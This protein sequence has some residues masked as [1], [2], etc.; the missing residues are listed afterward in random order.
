MSTRKP[1]AAGLAALCALLG[2]LAFASAPAFA[3]ESH[4]FSNAFAGE[5][6]HA[7]SDPQGVAIQQ[8]TGEVYVVDGRNDRVEVFSAAGT[9]IRAFGSRGNGNGQFKEPTLIAI[10][11]STG[12]PG[13]VYVLDT[14][15]N[16]VQVFDAKG[17][18]LRQI[19]GEYV[20]QL[21]GVNEAITGVAVDST[22]NLWLIQA[23]G[24]LEEFPPG[25]VEP[26]RYLGTFANQ[27]RGG[28]GHLALDSSGHL[29]ALENCGCIAKSESSIAEVAVFGSRGLA[30]TIDPAS[31]DLYVDDGSAVTHFLSPNSEGTLNDSFGQ[32]GPNVLRAGLGIAVNG[33]SGDVYVAEDAA[34][35]V[36]VFTPA[37]IAE[38]GIEPASGVVQT[39]ATLH[40]TVNPDGLSVSGCEF[41]WGSNPETLTSTADCSPTPPYT[42]NVAQPVQAQLDNLTA[43]TTYYY[44]LAAT[45]AEG[46]SYSITGSFTTL[47]AVQGLSTGPAEDITASGAKFTGTLSPDG[48]DAHYYFEYSAIGATPEGSCT[49]ALGCFESPAFPPGVDAGSGGTNC[50][51][52]GGAECAQVAAEGVV[53]NLAPNTVYHYRLVAVDT[54]GA[55]Y[56]AESQLKTLGPPTIDS[57]SAEVPSESKLG[58]TSVTLQAQITPDGRATTYHFEYGETSSYGTSVPATPGVIGAGESPESVPPG[59][60]SGLRVDTTYHY[61]VVATNEYGTVTGPDQTFTTLLASL[62]EASASSVT[63]TSATLDAQINPLGIDTSCRFE[64]LT[65]ESYDASGYQA[66]ATLSCAGDLGEGETRV[67]A[68]IH[69]QGLASD[70]LYHYRVIA[71]NALGTV[72]SPD[73][74]F[75]TQGA[76]TQ[77]SLP[78][79]RAWEMVTPP[80][81]Q[82]AGIFPLGVRPS[83]D[84]IQAAQAGNGITFGANGSFVANPAGNRSIEVNQVISTRS[85]PGVWGSQD[86]TTPH[87]EG[88]EFIA[89]GSSAEYKLFSNDLSLGFVEPAGSTALPPLPAGSEHTIYLRRADGG[90][91]AL[92]SPANV[93]QG[94]KYGAI[95]FGDGTP[96]MHHIIIGGPACISAEEQ[97]TSYEW[98][99]GKLDLYTVLPDGEIVNGG[100]AGV[101]HGLSNDG[102]RVVWQHGSTLYLRDMAKK[103]TV[104]IAEIEEKQ[105]NGFQ[106]GD[107][108]E[109]RVFFTSNGAL[110]VFEVTSGGGEPLAGHTM[111]LT[112]SGTVYGVIGASEDGSSVYFVD[113]A[114]LG[115][116]AEHGAEREGRNLYVEHYDQTKKAWVQPVFIAA[117]SREDRPTWG[118]SSGENETETELAEMVSRTSPNGRYLAFMSDRSLTGYDNRDANSGIPDEEVFEYDSNTGRLVCASCDPAGGRPVGKVWRTHG[119]GFSVPL[120]EERWVAASVPGWTI[121]GVGEGPVYQSRYLSNEGRL[122]FDSQDALVP[123]DV[124][125]TKD[126]YEYEPSGAGSCRSP[127]YGQSAGDVFV[128]G[129]DGCVALI[130]AGAS[131][132]ESSFMDASENGGDVFF[133]T[134]S[135]L[136][137][138]DE[139]TSVDIYD[140]HECTTASPCAAA[141][142]VA[143]PACTTGDSCKPA[144]APQPSTFGA[145]ASSTFSGAGNLTPAPPPVK[146]KPST[147]VQKR[148]KAVKACRAKHNPRQRKACE[149]QARKRYGHTSPSPR[150]P[151]S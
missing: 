19:S 129:S 87:Y 77:F 124:D 36:D 135:R 146:P 13:D 85:A 102:S 96:D 25:G 116:G 9:F 86:I 78:D 58:Q 65:A 93:Q 14:S 121:K 88:A 45:G 94:C 101:R 66:A 4:V 106:L 90:Y 57:S 8:S 140:A 118:G 30:L 38:V 126:V 48:T 28:V 10:D 127:A 52:P 100:L 70:T 44:R 79:G 104:Q 122:F 110:E 111:K 80:D 46:A 59:E 11:N 132:A 83:G 131:S 128:V 148:A 119:E 55:S 99:E 74:T 151:K 89:V 24:G 23:S 31:Q 50:Q 18:Y 136:S 115:D 97:T 144:P 68:S 62:V 40:G 53:G 5:G 76:A 49:E 12:L 35:R 2:A 39:E 82:G 16:R 113:S 37:K 56:G 139:D 67:P 71:K 15:R 84:D 98:S 81:K 112:T 41:E 117:L 69:L 103:E 47:P 54:F 150:R 72:E 125:G 105:S 26:G 63:A 107:E 130:S 33:A 120:W 75:T 21:I 22:G 141:E 138:R 20:Q 123:A 60:V 145:P 137:L 7:L 73:Q 109:S 1:I 61:R 142:V 51:P 108:E 147:N 91:E 92:V 114:V 32:G 43:A 42:G 34:N 17:D 6:E 27:S 143:P 64:Y 133:L 149:K 95:R 29:Y 134:V 3:L